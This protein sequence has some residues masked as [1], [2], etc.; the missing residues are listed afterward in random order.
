MKNPELNR[1]SKSEIEFVHRKQFSK[2]CNRHPKSKSFS[3][4]P[5][6]SASATK[7]GLS[8]NLIQSLCNYDL[9]NDL[10]GMKNK[11]SQELILETVHNI[12]PIKKKNCF[13]QTFQK[14]CI[15]EQPEPPP[16]YNNFD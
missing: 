3:E 2:S 7:G 6:G 11:S 4:I 10:N 14:I 1:D 8:Q 15:D 5:V 9:I 16:A 13:D 12:L